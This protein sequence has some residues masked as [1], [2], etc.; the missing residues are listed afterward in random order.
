MALEKAIE[1]SRRLA[2]GELPRLEKLFPI[3]F[4]SLAEEVRRWIS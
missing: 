3:G 2:G 4:G 1:Q